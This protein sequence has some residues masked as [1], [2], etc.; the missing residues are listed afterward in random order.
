MA[1]RANTRPVAPILQARDARWATARP[2]SD[3][4]I[5][6]ASHTG[7]PGIRQLG[8]QCACVRTVHL[9][10]ASS[11]AAAL[12]A[13]DQFVAMATNPTGTANPSAGMM[14][15]FAVRPEMETR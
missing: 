9:E 11:Q 12:A 6:M 4:A 13:T 8:S 14:T 10:M 1:S 5:A 7:G 3:A 2:I 15:A